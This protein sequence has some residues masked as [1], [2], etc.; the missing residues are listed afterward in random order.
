LGFAEFL[1]GGR[2]VTLEWDK[3]YTRDTESS[4][5]AREEGS[6]KLGEA[7]RTEKDRPHSSRATWGEGLVVIH[8][9][10]MSE[11]FRERRVT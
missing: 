7:R 1:R 4:W 2:G 6:G 10:R 8:A 5:L 3:A 11:E 9:R